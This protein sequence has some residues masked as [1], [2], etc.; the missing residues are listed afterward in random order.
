MCDKLVFDLSQE[1]EGSPNV[2][3]RKDW[4]N[5]LDNM[6]GNYQANQS[7]IDTSQLTNSNKWMSYREA[8]LTVP[9]LLS[10]WLSTT[11][12]KAPLDYS[13]GLKNW[14]GSII[15]SITVEYN[16]TTIIQ[17]TPF[18]NMWNSFKLLTSFSY[19]DVLSQGSTIGFYPDDP[20]SWKFNSTASVNGI[21]FSNNKIK[22]DKYFSLSNS[23][24]VN[25]YNTINYGLFNRIR[26]IAFRPEN[27]KG[28]S[29]IL[30][31]T[32]LTQD[33]TSQLWKSQLVK[34][35][36]NTTTD[37]ASIQYSILGVI[38]L[39]HLCDFFDK[40]PLLKG[41]FMKITMNLNNSSATIT[42]APDGAGAPDLM[43]VA[44][45]GVNV[46]VGGILPFM[47]PSTDSTTSTLWLNN[48]DVSYTVNL[49]IGDKMIGS[50]A[51]NGANIGTGKVGQNIL[52][53]IPAYTFN[54][55]F[56]EAYLS[57]SPKIVK[58]TDVYQYT[59]NVPSAGNI[60]TLIT[61]GIANIKSVLVIPFYASSSNGT[62][63][64][65]YRSPFDSAGA[66]TTGACIELNNFQI[67]VSG[68]N[69]IYN[70][71]RYSYEAFINQ[72]YGE[73]AVNGGLTDG[74]TSG[75]IDYLGWQNAYHYYYVNV[76]RMLPVEKS[77]PKSIQL[78]ANNINGKALE[79]MVFVEYENEMRF[80]LYTGARV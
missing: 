64:S 44:A 70:T 79:L 39:K 12:A 15:H 25:D 80:D 36:G 57:S 42:C 49:S 53:N 65:Q 52:L 74:L 11:A 48:V 63:F 32:G 10:G 22:E 72:L 29:T 20:L 45:G 43:T 6:N 55:T 21:G 69:A 60:N 18:I 2:F 27:I 40:L 28:G 61:N 77:V 35:A 73:N 37:Y 5:I 50:V 16:G 58:Y 75:L 30:V 34:R 78:I 66:G 4:L 71:Q 68:Q 9:M 23:L 46:P 54:P 3:V 31:S 26:N 7:I 56:E 24:E 62:P 76:E 41:A 51:P 13:I 47:V 14:F 67:Q 33:L 19:Q 59:V 8:Y 38:H 17:Q 1:V